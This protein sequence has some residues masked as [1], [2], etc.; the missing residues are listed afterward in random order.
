MKIRKDMIFA[1]LT[2]FCMC[3]LMF[4]VIPIRSGLPYDPWADIDDNG[5]IDMKD[6]GNVA[7]QFMTSGDPT[8]NV[9][10]TNWPTHPPYQVINVFRNE[11]FTI[12]PNIPVTKTSPWLCVAGYREA[13]I[14]VQIDWGS[15]STDGPWQVYFQTRSSVDNMIDWFNTTYT[16][17]FMGQ[18][19]PAGMPLTYT[20]TKP[21]VGSDVQ[22]DFTV[23]DQNTHVYLPYV[24]VS[25]SLYL[26][27]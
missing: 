19:N 11:N 5:K 18:S 14:Y 4:T 7:A 3:A 17:V 6:I 10:V 20:Y 12:Q 26:R 16:L 9:N 8:K 1:V 15:G 23:W 24:L 27:A 22:F 2:T 25:M 21:L 13:I